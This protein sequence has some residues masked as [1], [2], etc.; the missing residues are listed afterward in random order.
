M[1]IDA[2]QEKSLGQKFVVDAT[3]YTCLQ[4]AGKSDDLQ[5]TIDYAQI[6]R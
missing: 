6:Y 3:L 1:N 5:D 2:V 4:K